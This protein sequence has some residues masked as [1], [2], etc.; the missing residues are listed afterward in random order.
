MFIIE[1]EY[2]KVVIKT[3]GAELDSIYNKRTQLEYMWSA[4]PAFW[5][6]KSP[7]LFPIV[8]TLKNDRYYFQN[9][10]YSLSRHGFARETDFT[11]TEQAP[12]SVTFTLESNETTLERFPFSFRF[13]IVYS[14]DAE[15]LNVIYRGKNTGTIDLYF[16]VGGHPAFRLPLTAGTDYTDYYLEFNET[17]NAGRWPISKDGLIETNS[18]SLLDNTRRLQL[19]K[20]LFYTDAIV[21]KQLKSD[22]VSLLS[23]KTT[24]GLE[25]DFTGF[26]FLGIWAAKNADFVCI[27]PWCGIA[28]SVTANQ[29]LLDKEGINKLG[30]MQ[31]FE[32]VWSVKT[33]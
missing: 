2:L 28:D 10:E 18:I 15:K 19:K 31:T 8:G 17:E 11:A 12:S 25:F 5:S 4:D 7:V 23:Q 6:K 1:N 21:F 26:P 33:F 27:E 22:K 24:N 20:E 30:A 14:L 16:S 3:K 29:Q 32:R 9:K 13:D